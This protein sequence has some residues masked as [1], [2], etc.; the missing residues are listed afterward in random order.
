M[1]LKI[2]NLKKFKTQ[3]NINGFRE[4][5]KNEKNENISFFHLGP[6]NNWKKLLSEDTKKTIES[7]FG[8]EMKELGYL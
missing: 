6:E 3:E 4:A 1:Q 7:T 8:N 2:L 5:A